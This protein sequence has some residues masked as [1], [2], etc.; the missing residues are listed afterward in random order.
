MEEAQQN[1]VKAVR[2]IIEGGPGE[3][4]PRDSITGIPVI[5]SGAKQVE[6]ALSEVRWLR[7]AEAQFWE[8][9][10]EFDYAAKLRGKENKPTFGERMIQTGVKL[11]EAAITVTMVVVPG[12]ILIWAGE[13][14]LRLVSPYLRERLPAWGIHYEEETTSRR[15]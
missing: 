14:F 11:K 3:G 12:A 15:R 9:K 8:E 4:P 13:Q 7:E 1:E 6:M 10:G 5:P 2:G